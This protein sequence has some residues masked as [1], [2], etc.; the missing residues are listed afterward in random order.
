MGFRVAVVEDASLVGI[1]DLIEEFG[2]GHEFD[3]FG[4]GVVDELVVLFE[5]VSFLGF[6]VGNDD[7]AGAEVDGAGG[8]AG[9]GE[10]GVDDSAGAGDEISDEFAVAI[11]VAIDVEKAGEGEV[12]GTSGLPERGKDLVSAED[13]PAKVVFEDAGFGVAGT[14]DTSDLDA[15][16]ALVA[17][18]VIVVAGVDAEGDEGLEAIGGTEIDTDDTGGLIDADDFAVGN[19][20]GGLGQFADFFAT[21]ID[22]RF[23][24]GE[25]GFE[26]GDFVAGGLD[27]VVERRLEFLLLGEELLF[28]GVEGVAVGGELGAF[29][30]EVGGG[31]LRG[32]LGG[33]DFRI[34]GVFESVEGGLE[35]F[36]AGA[37]FADLSVGR[38]V[39][40]R[41]VFEGVA[42]GLLIGREG[43]HEGG[44]VLL[45][46]LT[47]S[48]DVEIV[49]DAEHL[50]DVVELALGLLVGGLLFAG[51]FEVGLRLGGGFARGLEEEE[52]G[53]AENQREDDE[54][55]ERNLQSLIVATCHG[56]SSSVPVPA[57]LF[58]CVA[59]RGGY[60]RL[61]LFVSD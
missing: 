35:F 15:G 7:V 31:L 14:D 58:R 26:A 12:F 28:L 32:F 9:F 20:E 18:D 38:G 42:V 6:L 36:D 5:L 54:D 25:E 1:A 8:L 45:V 11:L 48:V 50:L 46:L 21:L 27:L 33:L 39:A 10:F 30:L 22:I 47:D 40:R 2:D 41:E 44:L 4:A 23:G 51:L 34:A 17:G 59:A 3:A 60:R 55:D 16:L 37:L 43:R 56:L 52:G 29:L 53:D 13:G 57:N 61:P 24:V 19:F 49:S